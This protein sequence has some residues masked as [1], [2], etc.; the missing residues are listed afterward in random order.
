MADELTI[1]LSNI[2]QENQLQSN[3][4]HWFEACLDNWRLFVK[5]KLRIALLAVNIQLK[6]HQFNE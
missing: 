1:W 4:T 2:S 6:F 5:L 3:L